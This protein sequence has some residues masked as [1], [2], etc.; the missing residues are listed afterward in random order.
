MRAHPKSSGGS[1]TAE[2]RRPSELRDEVVPS[3][4]PTER[5]SPQPNAALA[6]SYGFWA[7]LKSVVRN[8]IPFAFVGYFGSILKISCHIICI[9]V[10]WRKC[11]RYDKRDI[12]VNGM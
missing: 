5:R 2:P 4:R 8:R 1:E 3:V 11:A 10:L 9:V 6:F 7:V 12:H